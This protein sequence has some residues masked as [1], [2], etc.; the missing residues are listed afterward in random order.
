M[1]RASMTPR[2]THFGVLAR[3]YRRSISGATAIEY[4]LIAG[5]VSIVIVAALIAIGEALKSPL[6][7]VG[8][9]LA[10]S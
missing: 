4:A 10:G 8:S 3:A 7:T 6:T 5:M 2:F 9:T 1:L